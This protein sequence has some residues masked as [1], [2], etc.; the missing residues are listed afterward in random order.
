VLDL[1]AGTGLLSALVAG[2]YP[3]SQLTLADISEAMLAQARKRFATQPQRI[4]TVVM[5]FAYDALPGKFDAVVSALAIH[6]LPDDAKR[7]LYVNVYRAL[8][9]GG[10]FI[11]ADSVA[12]LTPAIDRQ[13]D[14]VW[15]TQAR[16]KGA[17]E[18]EIAGAQERMRADRYAPL[19]AQLGWLADAGFGMVN[20]WYQNYRFAVFS[21]VRAL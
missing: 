15:L 7:S 19:A 8:N 5:D 18:A 16:R 11:N 12:G 10:I 20:C 21:G 2:A 3:D 14:A 17:S 1:G 6:H 9:P 13:Y 4:E